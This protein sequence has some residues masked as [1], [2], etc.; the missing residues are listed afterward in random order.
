MRLE[1]AETVVRRQIDTEMDKRGE[2]EAEL[3]Q[4]NAEIVRLAAELEAT[5][6]AARRTIS[7][8]N[9]N[10]YDSYDDY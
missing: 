3:E 4:H 7:Q 10:D 2:A 1:Q 5:K 8:G 6:K 9:I